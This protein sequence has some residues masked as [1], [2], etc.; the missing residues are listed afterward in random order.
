MIKQLRPIEPVF[1]N[2]DIAV[3]YYCNDSFAPYLGVSIYSLIRNSSNK[4][5]Y[6]ILILDNYISERNKQKLISLSA[7][8]DNIS[9]RF[10][11]IH[12][13]LSSFR[14]RNM[15]LPNISIDTYSRFIVFS[16]V[17]N[18]YH[19]ILTIDADTVVVDDI[20]K[21]LKIDIQ[22]YPAGAV[23]EEIMKFMLQKNLH[24]PKNIADWKE[25][26]LKKYFELLNINSA[27]YFNAGVLLINLDE[28]RRAHIYQ[29]FVNICKKG[30]NFY[31]EDQDILN[32]LFGNQ[33]KNISGR[34]NVAGYRPILL[35]PLYGKIEECSK[36]YLDSLENPG[37]IHYAGPLNKPWRNYGADFTD[38][39]FYYAKHTLWFG[40]IL[41]EMIENRKF[42]SE[43]SDFFSMICPQGSKRRSFIKKS[44]YNLHDKWHRW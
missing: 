11:P 16:S 38:E 5:Y 18:R 35:S 7:N 19:K 22:G 39:F 13:F 9:I 37:I 33:Y 31:Y 21:L 23:R 41:S 43:K 8:K 20:D 36:E 1:E 40:T 14:R 25:C 4:A 28:C 34:W 44:Y 10:I 15:N 6:D 27:R 29:R 24:I 12:S 30:I 3:C 26:P 2:N 42:D 17:F 32:I